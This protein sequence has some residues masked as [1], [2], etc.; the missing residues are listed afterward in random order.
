MGSKDNLHSNDYAGFGMLFS[1][2]RFI[3]GVSR[4][5]RAN[6]R[7]ILQYRAQEYFNLTEKALEYCLK[8]KNITDTLP[9]YSPKDTI[10][11]LIILEL[12]EDMFCSINKLRNEILAPYLPVTNLEEVL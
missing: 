11:K 9:I 8:A 7:E 5:I 12:C 3:Y 2:Q 4:D 6:Q 10:N 1:N